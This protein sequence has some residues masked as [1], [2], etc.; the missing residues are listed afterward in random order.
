MR[1][2]GVSTQKGCACVTTLVS[3]CDPCNFNRKHVLGS[4]DR[5]LLAL[6]HNRLSTVQPTARMTNLMSLRPRVRSTH[7]MLRLVSEPPPAR[8]LA[9]LEDPVHCL[10]IPRGSDAAEALLR[11]SAADQRFWLEEAARQD[12]CLIVV[13]AVDALELYSTASHRALAFRPA[14]SELQTRLALYPD[15]GKIRT[16]Q[17]SG[18]RAAERLLERAAGVV[19]PN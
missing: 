14:L 7:S 13:S 12:L 16:Q 8:K 5:C 2:L 1:P 11:F 18:S 9:A 15:A 4:M 10:V 17:L 6:M 3:G 19:G